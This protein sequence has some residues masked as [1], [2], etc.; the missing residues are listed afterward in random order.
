MVAW[1]LGAGVL[2][3]LIAGG[4][5]SVARR[6]HTPVAEQ[7]P[8]D[9]DCVQVVG[10]AKHQ[11]AL[12][13][14]AGRMGTNEVLET[15]AALV[16]E[17]PTPRSRKLVVMVKIRGS[18]VG[19]LWDDFASANVGELRAL[20]EAGRPVECPATIWRVDESRATG[21]ALFGVMLRLGTIKALVGA[22]RDGRHADG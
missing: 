20:A 8:K 2:G 17:K 11:E 15:T 18:K 3:L 16:P 21:G 14:V 19:E 1:L 22:G 6:P 12:W 9:E 13:E 10:V 7:G 5:W 4:A